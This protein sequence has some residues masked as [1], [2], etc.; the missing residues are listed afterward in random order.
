[1]SLVGN[2]EDLGLGDI[3][4]IVSL[5]QKSGVLSLDQKDRAGKVFFSNGEVIRATSSKLRL[6]LGDLLV[7]RGVVPL[8]TVK[9]ALCRQQDEGPYRCIGTILSEDYGISKTDIEN[10][11]KGQI[12]AIVFS[13]FS[14]EDGTFA[15]ELGDQK[16]LGEAT[17]N[18]LSFLYAKGLN[19]QWL[20]MEGTRRLDE[21]ALE[22]EAEECSE[23]LPV[24]D[25]SKIL[26]AVPEEPLPQT[27]APAP[28]HPSLESIDLILLLDDD[29][30]TRT[31]IQKECVTEGVE[32]KAFGTPGP[33]LEA[34][35]V[36]Q[37]PGHKVLAL[38]DLVI[39]REDGG[40]V[41]GG[42]EVAQRLSESCPALPFLMISDH[43]NA[44]SG[45]QLKEC[46]VPKVFIKPK[47][48]EILEQRYQTIMAKLVHQ[49]GDAWCEIESRGKR[50]AGRIDI[51]GEI[52]HE[53]G[54]PMPHPRSG[55]APKPPGLALLKNLLEE[56]AH[57]GPGGEIVL[58][59]LRFASEL[60]SRAMVL[61]VREDHLADMGQ[62]GF[63]MSSVP[64]G[65]RIP[66]SQ[67]AGTPVEQILQ[68]PQ[69]LRCDSADGLFWLER[70]SGPQPSE[71]Y[72]APLI[73]AGRVVAILYGDNAH[74]GDPLGDTA[75]LE[76]F[77][78]QAG[79]A[80]EKVLLE[81]RLQ[82]GT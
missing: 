17:L 43:P 68:S 42:L 60:M 46:G 59:I 40:G 24:A 33:F 62:F 16:V 19:T 44:A 32:V 72:M 29:P 11:V 26:E 53:I 25:W 64:G 45:R 54:E 37:K 65:L 80:M 22:T 61:R 21:G 36:A 30:T 56:L 49:I 4:Q 63:D 12:E 76:I 57:P 81:R 79:L 41:L 10:E 48:Q 51:A 34:C 27:S 77:L 3:L 66:R 13:F 35:V 50:P 70:F 78:S 67:I 71:V 38:V 8:D 6:N 28:S 82:N 20:A 75:P 23:Q 7:R 69:P 73:S 52:M 39:P 31:A 18:P 55:G 14:W 2:L 74:E 58:L 15:F 5:S 47:K 9:E 1:M